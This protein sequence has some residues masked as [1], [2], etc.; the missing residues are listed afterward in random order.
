MKNELILPALVD[1]Y[2]ALLAQIKPLQERADDIKAALKDTGL[3]RI[4]G[5]THDAV[6][7]LSERESVDA[8]ALRADLGEDI[9]QPY[10]RV[11]LVT[12]LKLTGKKVH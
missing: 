12:T 2:A 10:L 9:I 6:I 4:T 7:I 8:K 3:E 1:E 5:T 11:A